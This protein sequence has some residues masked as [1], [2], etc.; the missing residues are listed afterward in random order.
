MSK[1]TQNRLA[2]P[3]DAGRPSAPQTA[4]GAST[5]VP[6]WQAPRRTDPLPVIQPFITPRLHRLP[7]MAVLLQVRAEALR[8]EAPRSF[9][10]PFAQLV[11]AHRNRTRESVAQF[12]ERLPILKR[13]TKRLAEQVRRR[14]DR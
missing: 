7:K 6:A 4:G 3:S 13:L 10:H 8:K 5:L 14:S 2:T 1:S 12:L 11:S 9:D